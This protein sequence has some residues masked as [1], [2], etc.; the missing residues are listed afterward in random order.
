MNRTSWFLAGLLVV[1]AHAAALAQ[2]N[3]KQTPA[4]TLKVGDRA[5]KLQV[6]RWMQGEP[7]AELA[8]G[9][10][11]IVE[12]W[13]TWCGPCVVSIPHLNELHEKF[14]DRGLV[15]I[16]QDCWE[17]NESAVA[18]FIKKMGDKMTYRVA[19]DLKKDEKDRGRMAETW[20]AAAGQNGIPSAFVINKQGLIAWIGHPMS[21]KEPVLEQVLD[22]TF[23]VA[24]AA[25]AFELR[26]KNQPQVTA[27]SRKMGA[28]MQQK[29]WDEAEA[30][31]GEIARLIPE[32]DQANLDVTRFQIAM[33]RR[34]FP[35]AFEL[36]RRSGDAQ[37]DNAML[38]NMLAW[39]IAKMDPVDKPDL[40]LAELCANRANEA[41]KGEDAAILDTLAR[42]HFMKGD[43]T[44]AIELQTKAV[45][46]A[47]GRMKTVL[48]G[49]LKSY[50]EGKLPPPTD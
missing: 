38:Q 21:L 14:K 15:V 13:A 28:S 19:L 22:G 49:V 45:S 47:E 46:R 27:L 35:A 36:A 4:V 25:A 17:N 24:R 34:N 26:R 48:E 37:K 50:R 5:P 8:P 40:Q 31:L 1:S 7:V 29:N 3:P 44:R 6:A 12:F 20:M 16:G 33:K 23:D 39:E 42:V 11:Y 10:A 43:Q 32:E 18:P 9:T 2:D 30:A 41:T